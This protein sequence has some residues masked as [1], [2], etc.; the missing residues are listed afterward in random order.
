MSTL[1][2]SV[3]AGELAQKIQAELSG[4]PNVVLTGVTAAD[5]AGAGDL[6]FA[7]KSTYL[8]AAEKSAAS[9]ILAGVENVSSIKVLLRVKNVRVAFAQV[10]ELFFQPT[11]PKPGIHP[12]AVIGESVEV[13]TDVYIGPNCVVGSSVVLGK[14]VI[15]FGG[16]HV[17]NGC[18]L[19]DHTILHPNAVIYPGA[20]IGARVVI[21]AGTVIGSDGYGYVFDHGRHRKVLQI[22]QIIIEDDVEI[23]ANTAIDR[24]ALG[25]TV[26][27]AGTKIDNLVHL[28]HNVVIGRHCLLMGQVGFAGSTKLGDY[29]VIASQ[30][31]VAGHL[32][33]GPQT[34]VGAKSG[35]MRD[36]PAGATILGIPARPDKETKRQLIALTRLPDLLHRVRDLEKKLSELEA[37]SRPSE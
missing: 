32:T 29:G 22:G 31:G 11:L 17:G 34:T 10:L 7:E 3:T 16:N 4:D 23:G 2:F 19:G 9:A 37:K 1:K 6:T 35:V 18:D 26:I 25:P 27:G 8:D 13:G 12:S 33:L 15:L 14:G 5:L 28:A 24:G 36:T 21:H 20:Q 30:S